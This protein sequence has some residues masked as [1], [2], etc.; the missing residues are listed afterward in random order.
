MWSRP[1]GGGLCVPT[2]APSPPPPAREAERERLSRSSPLLPSC[3]AAS[4]TETRSGRR[5]PLAS[6]LIARSL[7]STRLATI[8]PRGP[9]APGR[10]IHSSP[11]PDPVEAAQLALQGP[12]DIAERLLAQLA[13]MLTRHLLEIV[14]HHEQAAQLGAVAFGPADL[15][16]EALVER[17]GRQPPDPSLGGLC[18]RVGVVGSHAVCDRRVYG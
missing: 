5:A 7:S 13:A 1:S 9:S 11:A 3:Q 8:S 16:G 18:K 15:L 10:T 6:T 12:G 17:P 4:P 14:D 2:R